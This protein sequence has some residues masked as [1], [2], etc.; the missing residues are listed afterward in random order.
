[1]GTRSPGRLASGAQQFPIPNRK[2]NPMTKII[3]GWV[4]AALLATLLM[5][6]G[7]AEA[8]VAI[9]NPDAFGGITW[10]YV[11]CIHE[12]HLHSQWRNG[13]GTPH[14]TVGVYRY[15]AALLRAWLRGIAERF[16]TTLRWAGV[17]ECESDGRWYINTGNGYYG[18]LQFSLRTWRAY[19]GH[20]MPHEQAPWY[21]ASIAEKV[22]IGSGLHHWPNC[23]YA[24]G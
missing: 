17:A 13:R 24:Y 22:R 2:E 21:Q 12:N 8:Q 6:G 5:F 9:C 18:G 14:H 20:G 15:E 19:G 4:A 11:G 23:G 1:M 10:R 7:R 3:A 16:F